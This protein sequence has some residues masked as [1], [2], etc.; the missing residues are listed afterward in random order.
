MPNLAI[1]S[2]K[3]G[4]I[5]KHEKRPKNGQ[6]FFENFIE[7]CKFFQRQALQS[8]IFFNIKKGHKTTL[9]H[10]TSAY[11][12]LNSHLFFSSNLIWRKT[13]CNQFMPPSRYWISHKTLTLD[14]LNNTRKNLPSLHVRCKK[15]FFYFTNKETGKRILSNVES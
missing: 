6:I 5:L 1:G 11:C 9:V 8:T 13:Y 2:L 12:K 3:K 10:K 4:Q 7:Y 15:R 14:R